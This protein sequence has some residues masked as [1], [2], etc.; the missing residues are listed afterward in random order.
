MKPLDRSFHAFGCGYV[1]AAPGN[2]NN[3]FKCKDGD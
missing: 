1:S 2:N 3:I